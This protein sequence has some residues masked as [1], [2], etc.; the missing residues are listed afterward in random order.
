MFECFLT[1]KK[2]DEFFFDTFAEKK[3]EQKYKLKT[4][5]LTI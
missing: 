5:H 1:K 4:K 3:T 2:F